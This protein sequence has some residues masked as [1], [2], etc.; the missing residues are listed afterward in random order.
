MVRAT[1]YGKVARIVV[2]GA[3]ILLA[4]LVLLRVARRIRAVRSTDGGTLEP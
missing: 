4:V 3:L 1:G 2:G